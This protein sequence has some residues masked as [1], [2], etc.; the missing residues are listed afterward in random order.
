[1]I[2]FSEKNSIIKRKSTIFNQTLVTFPPHSA[3]LRAM[4]LEDWQ[5]SAYPSEDVNLKS[6]IR[7][8]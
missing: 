2:H 6:A 7:N 8:Q 1:M 4:P 5:I 3:A